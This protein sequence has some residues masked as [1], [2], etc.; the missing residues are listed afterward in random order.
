MGLVGFQVYYIDFVLFD[1]LEEQNYEYICLGQVCEDL[2]EVELLLCDVD[3]IGFYLDVL[4]QVEVLG[5]LNLS[6]SG[7]FLEE[8]VQLC[9]Y[10]GMSDKLCFFGVYGIDYNVK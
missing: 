7:F 5:Q 3:I 2:V 4:K 6:L 1:W 9:C 10:V 8:V